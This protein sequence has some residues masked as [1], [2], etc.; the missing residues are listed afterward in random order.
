MKNLKIFD[1]NLSHN[2]FWKNA[3]QTFKKSNKD[4]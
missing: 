2:F 1:Q 3:K 4:L